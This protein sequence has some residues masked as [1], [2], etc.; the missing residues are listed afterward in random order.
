MAII[1]WD[2]SCFRLGMDVMD[3]THIEFVDLVNAA[4]QAQGEEFIHRFDALITHTRE[5][6]DQENRLM[7]ESGFPAVAEH[8]HEHARVLGE[9]ERFGQRV[10]RGQT[11]FGRSYLRESIAQW[12]PLHAM[13]MDSALAAHLKTRA[14]MPD[15]PI[16][17][18][19][20]KPRSG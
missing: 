1:E 10:R 8:R 15:G 11:S 6:F 18:N 13:T 5:H 12:F 19:V 16:I 7:I 20:H 9:F 14:S 4:A 3:A 2:D 17:C